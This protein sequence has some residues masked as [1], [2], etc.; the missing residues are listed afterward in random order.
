M[1]SYWHHQAYELKF[2][3][4]DIL[5]ARRNI[6]LLTHACTLDEIISGRSPDPPS[7]LPPNY[8]GFLIRSH[9][10]RALEGTIQRSGA[11]AAYTMTSY[12]HCYIDL[13]GSF[14]DYQGKFSAKTRATINR[15]IKRF[16][17]ECKGAMTFRAYSQPA[18]LQA[19]HRSA[20]QVSALTYQERLLDAG[21]PAEQDFVD[22]MLEDAARGN[23]RAY[24]LFRGE[25]PVAY[26]YCPVVQ[27]TLVYAFLGFDPSYGEWSVG[28]ILL[29]LSLESIFSEKAFAYFDFT[30]GESSQK[31]M[32]STH[33]VPCFNRLFMRD[34]RRTRLL[35]SAHRQFDRTSHR[36][37]TIVGRWGLK[38]TLKRLLR[39]T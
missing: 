22:R 13:S 12:Q 7:D 11:F 5:L 16:S 24:L 6:P 8:H 1:T 34:T 28:T 20:R 35:L 19:F 36:L 21:L 29:W 30:E 26:L 32:F 25:Q 3:V 39:G 18:D 10:G 9:P 15:K 2:Q 38:P 31:Q 23:V 14:T 17:T 4:S 37:G 33:R 27:K